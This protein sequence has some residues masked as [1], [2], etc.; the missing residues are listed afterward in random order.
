MVCRLGSNGLAIVKTPSGDHPTPAVDDRHRQCAA[1]R[2]RWCSSG[3]RVGR[4]RAAS[5]P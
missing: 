5:E 2:A 4:R 1:R 3:S